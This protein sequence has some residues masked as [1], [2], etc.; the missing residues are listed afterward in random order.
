MNLTVSLQ[1]T[2]RDIVGSKAFQRIVLSVIVFAAILVGLETSPELKRDYGGIMHVF[3]RIIAWLF[4]VEAVL[5]MAQ[6]GRRWVVYFKDPWNVFDF[7]ITVICLAPFHT[8]FA[9]VMRLVRILRALRLITQFPKLRLMVS[10]LLRSMPSM[11]HV[12]LLLFLL[13]YIYSV[14]GVFLWGENDPVHFGDLPSAFLT[15]FR[16]VTLEDWTDVMYTQMYGSDVYPFEFGGE[17]EATP[18]ARP[19]A[20]A[21]FFSSFV[22]LGTMVMLNLFIGVI[23]SS[24]EEAQAERDG[25]ESGAPSIDEEL[26]GLERQ[27][28]EM[29]KRIKSIRTR[30]NGA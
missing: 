5:K 19:I 1:Q 11:V 14:I 30:A 2:I 22:L 6:H 13:F 24:M 4:A 28:A 15:M 9:A 17:V 10:T 27:L 23:I 16:V 21:L 12:G 20:A 26:D 25:A 29:Q 18:S 3:D 8:E 7:I